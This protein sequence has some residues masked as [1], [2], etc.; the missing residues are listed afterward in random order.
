M[1]WDMLKSAILKASEEQ[2]Y[3]LL[4]IQGDKSTVLTKSAK[5]GI[6]VTGWT[7]SCGCVRSRLYQSCQTMRPFLKDVGNDV[8]AQGNTLTLM[9]GNRK[10]KQRGPLGGKTLP[11]KMT[12]TLPVG[13]QQWCPFRINMYYYK[14]D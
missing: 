2:D 7:Y 5:S 12:T 11:R 10:I 8:L 6:P 4:S 14:S 9:K 3:T 1:M 13:S